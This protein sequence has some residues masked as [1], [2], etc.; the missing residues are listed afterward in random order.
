MYLLI[1]P[2]QKD[3][4]RLALFDDTRVNEYE[5]EA[6]N[7]D[8]LRVIDECLRDAHA[9]VQDIEGI[10]TVVGAGGF[11]STRIGAIVANAFGYAKQIPVMGVMPAQAGDVRSLI[12]AIRSAAPGIYI[13]PSYSADANIGKK[14]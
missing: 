6:R 7:R 14:Q 3:R 12:P 2:T 8:L 13:S 4:I 1:D 9:T 5:K 10:A 11:T